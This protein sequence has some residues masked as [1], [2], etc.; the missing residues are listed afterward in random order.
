[1][2]V[3]LALTKGALEQSAIVLQNLALPVEDIVTELAL[4]NSAV[5]P[6]NLGVALK[7]VVAEMTLDALA[8]EY[9][10]AKAMQTVQTVGAVLQFTFVEEALLLLVVVYDLDAT[11][12]A[13]LCELCPMLDLDDLFYPTY[14]ELFVELQCAFF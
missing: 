13:S 3:E 2:P 5:P 12:L 14:A 8:L 9:I 7:L 4:S 10:A 6:Y 1:M 11:D